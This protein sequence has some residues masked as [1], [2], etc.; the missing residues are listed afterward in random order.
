[1]NI[2][3]IPIQFLAAA[4]ATAALLA[5]GASGFARATTSEETCIKGGGR[6]ADQ[7]GCVARDVAR[8]MASPPPVRTV[9]NGSDKGLAARA[10]DDGASKPPVKRP[11][12]KYRC[13]EF[14]KPT[15]SIDTIPEVEP[16]FAPLPC[17][18][19]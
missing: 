2:V 8:S 18:A 5:L 9:R 15:I 13:L 14:D 6:W 4:V 12:F 10:A 1:M 16:K 7:E 19:Q 11:D 17:K 3:R